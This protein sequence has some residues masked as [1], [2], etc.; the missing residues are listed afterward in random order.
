MAFCLLS[1]AHSKALV[2]VVQALAS[3][4]EHFEALPLPGADSMPDSSADLHLASSLWDA[5]T[6]ELFSAHAVVSAAQLD[7]ATGHSGVLY[8]VSQTVQ[9]SQYVD[10]PAKLAR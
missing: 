4:I 5:L 8:F 2:Q 6:A 7:E 1:Q 9:L 3:I 10:F